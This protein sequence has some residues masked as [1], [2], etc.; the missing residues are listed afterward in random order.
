MA[1]MVTIRGIATGLACAGI[2]FQLFTM[3]ANSGF[4]AL[5]PSETDLELAETG[6]AALLM[7]VLPLAIYGICLLIARR[8][9]D[10]VLILPAVIGVLLFDIDT[11]IAVESSTSSTAAISLVVAPILNLVLVLPLGIAIGWL[12]TRFGPFK[13]PRPD[14]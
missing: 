14:G 9:V 2:A 5:S 3:V 13:T 1:S 11:Y 8:A 12:L 4:T 6:L 10:A 7:F